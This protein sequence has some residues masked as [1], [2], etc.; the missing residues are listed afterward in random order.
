MD[1]LSAGDGGSR[2]WHFLLWH[3]WVAALHAEA[4]V[5]AHDP[6]AARHL[7]EAKAGADRGRPHAMPLLAGKRLR[8][9]VPVLVALPQ[10]LPG[11]EWHRVRAPAI[12]ARFGFGEAA[13][14]AGVMREDGG[15][16]VECGDPLV[17]Q[18]EVP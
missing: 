7:A 14:C 5:L 11:Q 17:P 16:G 15:F 1:L 13:G 10:P 3:Q 9:A 6:G 18:Q 4:A 2:S 12:G 8:A